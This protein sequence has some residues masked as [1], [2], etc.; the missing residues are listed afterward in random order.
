IYGVAPRDFI[1]S[2]LSGANDTE[3]FHYLTRLVNIDDVA[4]AAF[5]SYWCKLDWFLQRTIYLYNYSL[6]FKL[7]LAKNCEL[8]LNK[9]VPCPPSPHPFTWWD[10]VRMLPQYIPAEIHAEAMI[11]GPIT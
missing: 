9:L 11:N 8:A 2:T 5:R 4:N 1:D 10:R 7:A 6:D 3:P